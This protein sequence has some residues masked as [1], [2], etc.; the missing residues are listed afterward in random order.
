MAPKLTRNRAALDAMFRQSWLCKKVCVAIAEDMTRAG[1]DIHSPRSPQ[2]VKRLDRA[3]NARGIWQGVTDNTTWGR[4]YGGSLAFLD[5]DG[6]D[7]AT[8]LMLDTVA[9]GQ[10]NGLR[11]FDRHQLTPDLQYLVPSGPDAGLPMFYNVTA[12]ASGA[13]ATGLRL[14]YSR[15]IR[16]GGVKLPHWEAI[17]EMLWGASELEGMYDRLTGFDTATA[18]VSE[19]VHRAHIRVVRLQDFRKNLGAGGDLEENLH[20]F[21]AMVSFLQSNNR[22]LCLDKN[23]EYSASTYSFAGLRDVLDAL[24]AQLA[25]AT[26]IPLVRLFGQSPTGMNATGESDLATYYESVNAKQERDLREP[27]RVVL[28]LVHRSELGCAPPPEF[29]FQ[30]NS[31]RKLSATDKATIAKTIGDNMAAQ[32]TAGVITTAIAARELQQQSDETGI[33][34]NVTDEHIEQLEAAP[35]IPGMLGMPGADPAADLARVA[36]FANGASA[37]GPGGN[38]LARVRAFAEGRPAGNPGGD[39]E[40][41]RAFATGRPKAGGDL[42]RMREFAAG[43]E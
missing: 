17:G 38:D 19:L 11:V 15:V 7:P 34:T 9:R 22:L 14:H 20:K 40:R 12:D 3:L 18:G 26:G 13:I 43:A 41:I 2:D 4:L 10:F 28:E 30:F 29:E 8:T 42:D 37:T 35:P 1:I 21:L 36:A 6:Q 39:L 32:V 31:L 16:H 5:I 33:F 25:G 27:L 23:D 24:G